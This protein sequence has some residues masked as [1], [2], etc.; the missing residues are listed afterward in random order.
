MRLLSHYQ[1]A[2]SEVLA[3]V[4]LLRA[5][6]RW[7]PVAISAAAAKL[8]FAIL[9][10]ASIADSDFC[11]LENCGTLGHDTSLCAVTW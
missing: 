8:Y 10:G 9:H 7:S 4:P 3:V 5:L 1:R 11:N 2:R 6:T